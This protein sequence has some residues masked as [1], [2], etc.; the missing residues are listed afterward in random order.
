[1]VPLFVLPAEFSGLL[2]C[3]G[4]FLVIALGVVLFERFWIKKICCVNEHERGLY[5]I[6]LWELGSVVSLIIIYVSKLYCVVLPLLF[7]IAFLSM[8]YLVDIIHR[9]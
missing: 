9:R 1:M 8:W 3:I 6:L 5:R 7:L 4:I 2:W